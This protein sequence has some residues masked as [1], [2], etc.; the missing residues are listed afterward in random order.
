MLDTLAAGAMSAG[1]S[2][3]A[4]ARSEAGGKQRTP[5]PFAIKVAVQD[6]GW[7]WQPS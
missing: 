6:A 1:A 7:P 2:V 5:R 4:A 3:S